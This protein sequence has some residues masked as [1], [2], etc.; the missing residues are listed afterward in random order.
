MSFRAGNDI[1]TTERRS[2]QLFDV[3]S[4]LSCLISLTVAENTTFRH[5]STRM[6][7]T[8]RSPTS[9]RRAPKTGTSVGER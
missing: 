5:N 3:F 9:G 7:V 1:V 4:R 6:V 2:D 8:A